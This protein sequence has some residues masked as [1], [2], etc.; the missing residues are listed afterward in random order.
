MIRPGN[1][2]PIKRDQPQPKA[3]EVQSKESKP[4]NEPPLPTGEEITIPEPQQEMKLELKKLEKPKE[5][6]EPEEDVAYGSPVDY[7]RF[8]PKS[9]EALAYTELLEYP[10]VQQKPP[11][12]Q[13]REDSKKSENKPKEDV[14]H[15]WP[16][17]CGRFLP[18]SKESLHYTE[19]LKDPKSG[20]EE[21]AKSST[22]EPTKPEKP[23]EP[24]EDIEHGWP[25][26]YEHFLPKSKE[27]LQYTEL[28]KYPKRKP[29]S[30]AKAN[31]KEVK[32]SEKSKKPEEGI[33]HGS[34][35]DYEHFLPQS[36]EALRY[37][38]LLEYP[39]SHRKLSVEPN[40]HQLMWGTQGVRGV[41]P[42]VERFSWS[43]PESKSPVSPTGPRSPSKPIGPSKQET[44]PP[45][46]AKPTPAVA[47][48]PLSGLVHDTN[49]ELKST[50]LAKQVDKKKK[51]T[52]RRASAPQ[53][54]KPTPETKISP[55]SPSEDHVTPPEPSQKGTPEAHPELK[56]TTAVRPITAASNDDEGPQEHDKRKRLDLSS[57]TPSTVTTPDKHRPEEGIPAEQSAS[58]SPEIKSVPVRPL[59]MASH[60]DSRQAAPAQLAHSEK[61]SDPLSH[62][63]TRRPGMRP[64]SGFFHAIP[65]GGIGSAPGAKLTLAE[66]LD[67]KPVAHDTKHGLSHTPASKAGTAPLAPK[68]APSHAPSLKSGVH[69]KERA[70]EEG[71]SHATPVPQ[72][73]TTEAAKAPAEKPPEIPEPVS[74]S[75]PATGLPTGTRLLKMSTNDKAYREM[76]LWDYGPVPPRKTPV[77]HV[78]DGSA[79]TVAPGPPIT[80]PPKEIAA[81]QQP[82]TNAAHVSKDTAPA[83]AKAGAPQPGT[84]VT[85][86]P[87]EGVPV[88]S[89][90]AAPQTAAPASRMAEQPVSAAA[91]AATPK[92]VAPTAKVAEVVAK[93]A[94]AAVPQATA[95]TAKVPMETVS[96]PP[97]K[98]AAPQA[99]APT[100]KVSRETVV[101]P[102]KAAAQQGA[103]PAAEV[104]KDAISA[105]AKAAAPEPKAP[106][107]KVP[108]EATSAPD[109]AGGPD[110]ATS[111]T[112]LSKDTVVAPAKAA[113]ATAEAEK[114]PETKDNLGKP[115]QESAISKQKQTIPQAG[116][117]KLTISASGAHKTA[118]EP[119][120]QP[121]GKPV[122]DK[123]PSEAAVGQRTTSPA[124]GKPTHEAALPVKTAA[125]DPETGIQG[126]KPPEEKPK[127][128]TAAAK[129]AKPAEIRPGFG[130]AANAAIEYISTP[131]PEME[132]EGS[133]G[134]REFT[135]AILTHKYSKPAEK[136][137]FGTAASTSM[138]IKSTSSPEIKSESSS[139]PRGVTSAAVT[140]KT[141]TE[142]KGKDAKPTGKKPAFGI[143]ANATVEPKSPSSPEMDLAS[144]GSKDFTTAM[145]THKSLSADKHEPH[146]YKCAKHRDETEAQ[147]EMRKS[148]AKARARLRAMA[149][150]QDAFEEEERVSIVKP[151]KKKKKKRK[152]VSTEKEATDL[153]RKK[154]RK[155]RL[156]VTPDHYTKSGM[157]PCCIILLIILFIILIA[158]L[159]LL[160]PQPG[161]PQDTTTSQVAPTDQPTSRRPT[162]STYY[163]SSDVCNAEAN[164]LKSLLSTS[165]KPCDNFYEYVCEA[166]SRAHAVPGGGAG[167]VV[168]SDTILQ[169]KLAS[170]MEPVL[171]SMQDADVKIAAGLHE[172]CMRRDKVGQNGNTVIN[173]AR[174]LFRD[175]AIKEWPVLKNGTVTTE[176]AWMF[177]GE[178]VRDLN[179]AAL[180]SVSVGVSPKALEV[181]AIELDKP[182]LVFSCND[183]S[184]PAVT[185]LF[186]DALLEVMS[187]FAAASAAVG[188]SDVDNVMNVFIRLA[189]S[190]TLAASPDTS[191]IMYTSVKLVELESG[192]KNFLEKVFN[193]IVKIDDTT[194][195]VLKS[196]D[197]LRNDLKAA[198]QELPPQA[199]VNYLG[200]MALVKAAPFF[201]EKFSNLRQLFGKD[202]LDRTLPDVS[203]TK[204]L[205]LL[206]VQQVLPGCF[207]KA[208]AKLRGMSHTDLPLAEW[209]SRLESTFDRH[210]ERVAWI[211]ELSAL[212]VRY[213]LRTNRIAAFPWGSR[214]EPCAPTPQEIPRRSEHPLRFFHQVSM[215]QEQKRL[216]L[217]LKTGQEVRALRGEARSEL[218]TIP[219]YDVMRQAVH[220]PMALFNTSVASN[221]TM[222]SFH[223]SRVAVRLYRA[224]VQV[225]FPNIY[226]RDAPLSL[227]EEMARRLD[228]LLSCF[229]EDLSKLPADVRGPVSVDS[230]KFRGALLQHAAAIRLALSAFEDLQS[231]W[232]V[233]NVDFRFQDLP[234]F[235]SGALFFLYYALDNCE[236]ADPVYEEHL[237]SWMPAHYRVNAAL[238]HVPN[239]ASEFNCTGAQ[240]MAAK[241]VCEVFKTSRRETSRH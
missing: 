162:L 196:P 188:N 153:S 79:A 140:R 28:L 218:A 71:K 211:G 58:G 60:D 125:T 239:F 8:L 208:A 213:R 201:P 102:L 225:L 37:A 3:D 83:P 11:A 53:D 182:R 141:P 33:E 177:A 87:K 143:A 120:K 10:K 178:L 64:F 48:R 25:V 73:D 204:A 130:T 229:E 112:K 226:E 76:M 197:Y 54:P 183:A 108:Q 216:Q 61:A 119:T 98:A 110:L 210:Q 59:S 159:Y 105:P 146:T 123:A 227:N 128:I 121:G 166:W 212:I 88:A 192:Y 230:A 136:P 215:L 117:A 57:S 6:K 223:L 41:S 164:Y 147:Y 134:S 30:I 65:S 104:P 21:S 126:P 92:P 132:N 101:A 172:D 34:P 205:C 187:S 16:V 122:P 221:T 56:R 181:A 169:D 51:E 149:K 4:P 7:E 12:K 124:L 190:P 238:R 174:E 222:F 207:A 84:A 18:Q 44:T 1:A 45:P 137:A 22:K 38:E 15:G 24:R 171:L 93:G 29:D 39:K 78:K 198:M 27:A 203:Q 32:K 237:G 109:K 189:S 133:P 20:R 127:P 14:D 63:T 209:L 202:V 206:A 186:K 176:V 67:T 233:W 82:A 148:K 151:S 154:D 214:Q 236:S 2:G 220:V 170:D 106:S 158:L 200:F 118:E 99:T 194:E 94:K 145:V 138:E 103:I 46:A 131:S 69:S 36:K 75:G 66:R 129:D 175:W 179:V 150:A 114:M 160:W 240:P 155:S 228:R 9:K 113:A 55:S 52:P 116:A 91:K 231:V 173:V 86:L 241:K 156:S 43:S 100:A 199:V 191:P 68:E 152:P 74:V 13:S 217:V 40:K 111:T 219:E 235:N 85:K 70:K 97:S 47:V 139:G 168:S 232:R 23:D 89:K 90:A 19:L 195:V 157:C 31:T 26:D 115:H 62:P 5:S 81:P 107:E 165:T 42:P 96:A 161:T 180:A 142:E 72:K 80:I 17:D 224:L 193:S 49:E 135:A 185:K 167:G 35:V 234:D 184:R 163:C 144:P 95:T 77:L 50:T